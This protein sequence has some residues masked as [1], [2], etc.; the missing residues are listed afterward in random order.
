MANRYE[1]AFSALL[2]L[3]K[4]EKES[5]EKYHKNIRKSI[6][7]IIN[8]GDGSYADYS[9]MVE[10]NELRAA[11]AIENLAVSL[12]VD[13]SDPEF[14]F[15]PVQKR[16]EKLPLEEQAKSRPFQIILTAGGLK[17]GI[18]FSVSSDVG[19]Y[20]RMLIQ[21]EY[22]VDRLIIVRLIDPDE[23]AYDAIIARTNRLNKGSRHLLKH[24]TL[25]EFWVEHFGEDEYNALVAAIN[26]FNSQ[27][28][29]II[30]FS[31]VVTPTNVAIDRFRE[32]TGKMLR[33]R[34]YSSLIP[35]DVYYSQVRI[36]EQN[37]LTQGRWRAMIGR[38]NFAI[39]FITSEWYFKMHQLTESFDLTWVVAGYLKS[40][41]QLLYAVIELSEETGITIRSTYRTIIEFS[42]DNENQI[43]STLG[44]LKAVLEHNSL[45]EVNRYAHEHIINTIENWC[46]KKRNC[47]FHKDVLQSID[48]LNEIREAVLQLYFLILGSFTIND[49]Q[50]I[51]LGATNEQL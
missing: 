30:G 13:N 11:S 6:G 43:D 31:T 8:L 22:D 35:T 15:Y 34:T 46:K 40:V 26:H 28:Q 12:F 48:Q 16:Y 3:V 21:D 42:K 7:A 24:M 4:G 14:S 17:T 9:S 18:V 36:M 5:H 45:M 49:N 44:S 37:Y 41:E 20:Y 23:E 2:E 10:N 39:S 25:K 29:E 51:R 27:A 19:R 32:T 1:E 33:E 50:L 38:K 47:F